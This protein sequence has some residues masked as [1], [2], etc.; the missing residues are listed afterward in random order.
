MFTLYNHANI[1]ILV[2]NTKNNVIPTKKK[3]FFRDDTFR[4][5]ILLFSKYNDAYGVVQTRPDSVAPA[6]LREVKI[7]S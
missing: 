4:N 5:I 7:C 2:T 1:T 3:Y 6:I